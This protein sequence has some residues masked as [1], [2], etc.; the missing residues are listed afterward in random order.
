MSA[1]TMEKINSN[2]IL[3]RLKELEGHC[4]SQFGECAVL[5][6]RPTHKWVTPTEAQGKADPLLY[7]LRE[8]AVI[9]A[10]KLW[11][12]LVDLLEPSLAAALR[13][14]GAI[15]SEANDMCDAVAKLVSGLR[16]VAMGTSSNI[17]LRLATLHKLMSMRCDV[18]TDPQVYLDQFLLL[19][20]HIDLSDPKN[21]LSASPEYAAMIAVNGLQTSIIGAQLLEKVSKDG[22]QN[23]LSD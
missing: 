14:K 13:N 21:M 17:T 12:F 6:Q 22:I 2:N 3:K 10:R 15:D 8:H 5:L 20:S 7:K 23:N 19:K 11:G 16:E 4:S 18:G 1:A 9:G